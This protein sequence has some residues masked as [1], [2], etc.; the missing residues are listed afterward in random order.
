MKQGPP[1][2]LPSYMWAH[3]GEHMATANL[4]AV[5]E[6]ISRSTNDTSV[7]PTWMERT[8]RVASNLTLMNQREILF[9]VPEDRAD[10]SDTAEL[11]DVR[12]SAHERPWN[13]AP[14][15]ITAIAGS[16]AAT[17]ETSAGSG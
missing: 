7:R 15:P 3:F 5:R 17:A 9:P 13:V 8:C 16:T 12:L 6:S 14:G 4:Y 2:N 10:G 11:G 1:T